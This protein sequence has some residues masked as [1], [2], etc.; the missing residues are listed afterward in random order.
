MTSN[1]L[2]SSEIDSI[3]QKETL[4]AQL[5]SLM[6]DKSAGAVERSALLIVDDVEK[7]MKQ[8]TNQMKR[9]QET[10]P[11]ENDWFLQHNHP[12]VERRGK[13]EP[14]SRS[15]QGDQSDLLA[16][17][18]LSRGKKNKTKTTAL[19]T[20]TEGVKY[21]KMTFGS[22]QEDVLAKNKAW[23]ADLLASRDASLPNNSVS[24]SVHTTG[25]MICGFNN[26]NNACYRNSV[27]QCFVSNIKLMKQLIKKELGKPI[28]DLSEFD[29]LFLASTVSALHRNAHI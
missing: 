21:E 10:F 16:S 15:D 25:N 1:R 17:L 24:S 4:Q 7:E 27:I 12:I 20:N 18:R 6:T 14:K 28:D 19:Y 5:E 2:S 9:N 13:G 23:L 11:I 3:L 8:F 29:A 22:V 26:G